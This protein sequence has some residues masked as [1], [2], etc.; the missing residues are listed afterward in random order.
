MGVAI[1]ADGVPPE[2][3]EEE[4]YSIGF[5]LQKLT[6]KPE[7]GFPLKH[8]FSLLKDQG[9]SSVKLYVTIS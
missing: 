8:G 1:A 6:S 9:S 4:W 5:L 2:K 7:L 3:R